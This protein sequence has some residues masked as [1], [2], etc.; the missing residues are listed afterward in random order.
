[1][2]SVTLR[3]LA[4][5]YDPRGP[6]ALADLSLDVH[7]GEFFVLVGPSACGKTTV[8]RCIAGL[9]SPSAGEILI[10]DR[11]VTHLSPGERDVAM[12]FQSQALYP[13][14]SVRGNIAFGPE[15]R[16]GPAAEIT[17]RVD[18]AAKR[19]GLTASAAGRH[20]ELAGG[21]RPPGAP[22]S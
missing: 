6:Q 13:H 9:E 4:K 10:G 14:L 16:G 18:Q 5:T 21:E 17:R 3:R 8:L 11:D 2:A 22:G 19:L 15:A 12:V 7:D 20:A 1:M